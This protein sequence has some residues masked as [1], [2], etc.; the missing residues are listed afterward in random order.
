MAE[1]LSPEQ[2]QIPNPEAMPG[3]SSVQTAT[4]QPIVPKEKP[5]EAPAEIIPPQQPVSP[6]P[7]TTAL[8]AD[9]QKS[10]VL[11]EI[12]QI[13]EEDLEETYQKMTPAQKAVF[14]KE[15]E[16]TAAEIESMLHKVK[17]KSKKVFKLIFSW[18]RV[19]PGLSKY[20][21]KQE[22]KIKTDEVTH[23]KEEIDKE[24]QARVK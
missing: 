9:R 4:E 5:K 24:M 14:R 18:L 15:G 1:P 13:M 20:F 7:Q 21:L 19:V 11:E 8:P 12:E 3:E 22:A 23:L 2:P 16:K 6:Q 17:F 10:E